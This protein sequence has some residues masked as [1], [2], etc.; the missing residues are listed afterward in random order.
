MF[1]K[2]RIYHNPRCSQSRQTLQLLRIHKGEPEII[3]YMNTPFTE[4]ELKRILRLL[5][6]RPRQLLRT[7]ENEYLDLQLDNP[8]LT[9]DQIIQ[10]M[11]KHPKLIERPI[12]TWHD[13]AAIGRPPEA[14]L[15]IL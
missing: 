11:V 15:E 8:E 7:K 4:V 3:D 2:I 14:V 1:P 13:K 9:D 10:I 6:M 12:V 5:N